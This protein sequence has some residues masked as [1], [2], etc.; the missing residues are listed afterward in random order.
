MPDRDRRPQRRI[1]EIGVSAVATTVSFGLVRSVLVGMVKKLTSGGLLGHL[2]PLIG[3]SSL[4]TKFD[5]SNDL[6]ELEVI[7]FISI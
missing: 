2:G 4:E 1:F 3:L 6:L 7:I 5:D